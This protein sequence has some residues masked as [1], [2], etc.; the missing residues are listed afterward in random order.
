MQY[1]HAFRNKARRPCRNGKSTW[2]VLVQVVQE[3]F[4][5][6]RRNRMSK[7]RLKRNKAKSTINT[8]LFK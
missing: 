7:L 4:H 5:E 8:I 2:D 1:V 3:D 6:E